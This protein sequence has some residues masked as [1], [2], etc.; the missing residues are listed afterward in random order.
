M[1]ILPVLNLLTFSSSEYARVLVHMTEEEKLFFIHLL[2][3]PLYKFI[4]H[5]LFSNL[6]SPKCWKGNCPIPMVIL[7]TLLSAFFD[8]AMTFLR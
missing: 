5:H 3:A 1:S 2:N 6:K 8:C 7:V 4:S